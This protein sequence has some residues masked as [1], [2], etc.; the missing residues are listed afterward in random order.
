MAHEG[1]AVDVARAF[2][3]SLL[4]VVA[5]K[6]ENGSAETVRADTVP[7]ALGEPGYPVGVDDELEAVVRDAFVDLQRRCADDVPEL[8]ANMGCMA[9]VVSVSDFQRMLTTAVTAR[10]YGPENNIPPCVHR[11]MCLSKQIGLTV[12]GQPVAPANVQPFRVWLTRDEEARLLG[13]GSATESIRRRMCAACYVH[14]LKRRSDMRPGDGRG[15][16]VYKVGDET[17]APAFVAL[18]CEGQV[19]DAFVDG[20]APLEKVSGG[21]SPAQP[22]DIGRLLSDVLRNVAFSTQHVVR[23]TLMGSASPFSVPRFVPGCLRW[24]VISTG[25]EYTGP[26]APQLILQVDCSH[27]HTDA[28]ARA[29]TGGAAQRTTVAA[30]SDRASQPQ[31]QPQA[32]SAVS[33]SALTSTSKRAKCVYRPGIVLCGNRHMLTPRVRAVPPVYSQARQRLMWRLE[34]GRRVLGIDF[35]C[36]GCLAC[37]NHPKMAPFPFPCTHNVFVYAFFGCATENLAWISHMRETVLA[38]LGLM[39]GRTTAFPKN[40]EK[41]FCSLLTNV[42]DEP[43]VLEMIQVCVFGQKKRTVAARWA[44]RTLPDHVLCRAA[45]AK[46]A[47]R[48]APST[49]ITRHTPVSQFTGAVDTARIPDCLRR[50]RLKL[51]PVLFEHVLC[52]CIMYML[53][54]ERAELAGPGHVDGVPWEKCGAWLDA[55]LLYESGVMAYMARFINASPL[56]KKHK[57]CQVHCVCRMPPIRLFLAMARHCSFPGTLGAEP[58]CAGSRAQRRR[59]SAPPAAFPAHMPCLRWVHAVGAARAEHGNILVVPGPLQM[60][61]WHTQRLRTVAFVT[62]FVCP[63]CGKTSLTRATAMSKT[64]KRNKVFG[65]DMVRQCVSCRSTF[66]DPPAVPLPS[67]GMFLRVGGVWWAACCLC[68]Q[69]VMVTR[70]Y[71]NWTATHVCVRCTARLRGRVTIKSPVYLK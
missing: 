5:P 9:N 17:F 49:E 57:C 16:H 4:G 60:R 46:R 28:D 32:S 29:R 23:Y 62:V 10:G 45:P 70:C 14:E 34:V 6:A 39:A 44:P 40:F 19:V 36:S 8:V 30:E 64:D 20:V 56:H 35:M 41:K 12:D 43:R 55:E 52:M 33:S 67:Y 71:T 13:G 63:G 27:M 68:V 59:P 31:A 50:L 42:V 47:K 58:R 22:D 38:L 51:K 53:H 61:K 54:A 3:E 11:D 48:V 69:P 25:D 37:W 18:T 1:L 26:D 15:E 7:A 2:Q 24:K 66:D 65:F 21:D